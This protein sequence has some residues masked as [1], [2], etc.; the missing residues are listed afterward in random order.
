MKN[1]VSFILFSFLFFTPFNF[2]SA[3]SFQGDKNI[4]ISEEQTGDLYLSGENIVIDAPIQ[5]DLVCAGG[6][7]IIQDSIAQD[8]ILVGGNLKIMGFVG[9]DIRVAGGTIFINEHVMG[10]LIVAG[11]EVTVGKDA[12]IYG[13]L[14]L[15]G[16]KLNMNGVAKGKVSLRG[17]EVFWN[18]IAEQS[19]NIKAGEFS[20]NGTLQ[21]PST[22]AA[23]KIILGN[24]ARILSDM[25][26]WT[27]KGE[28]DFN[29]AIASGAQHRFNTDLQISDMDVDWRYLGIGLVTFWI[30]RLL[31]AAVLIILMIWMF[32]RF[33]SRNSEEASRNYVSHL[34][35]GAIY[36]IGIP[37]LIVLA[38]MTIIGIPVGFILMLIYGL[39]IALGHVLAAV[40]IAYGVNFYYEKN[41]NRRV[42]FLVALCS[43][44]ALKIIGAV[45]LLGVLISLIIVT[46]A[47]GTL[48]YI[49]RQSR[50]A[51][52]SILNE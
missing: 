9:D 14:K 35:Y 23:Q 12:N 11:G 32:H 18:G 51:R 46:T 7:I 49:W 6:D 47:F 37:V 8:V 30:Y 26:Y 40:L 21:G 10:D 36:I 27:S 13:E 42:L 2:L 15:V 45:P 20:L 52:K 41:W 22:I 3:T 29:S 17:G 16:G 34:G 1:H 33:F 38:F 5:G 24:D 39:T 50:I 19:F 4:T 25:E 48:A 44:L 43:Y 31:T 28:I